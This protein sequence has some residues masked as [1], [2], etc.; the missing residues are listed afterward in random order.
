[1]LITLS[2]PDETSAILYCTQ[3]T[4]EHD[5]TIETEPKK[6]TLEMIV[7]VEQE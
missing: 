3:D 1:M 5:Y 2:L 6:I 4:N 7:K